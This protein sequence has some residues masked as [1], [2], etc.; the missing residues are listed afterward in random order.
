M[1]PARLADSSGRPARAPVS[2]VCVANDHAVRERTLDRSIADHLH[3]APDTEYL[4]I[5]NSAGTFAS[6][7]EALNHGASVARHD[8]VVFVH[9]DVYLHSLRALEEAANMLAQ[10]PDIGMHGSFGIT[11]NGELVGRIRDRVVVLGQ[12]VAGPTDVDSLDEVLFMV[13]REA[14]LREPLVDAPDLAWHAYAVEYG[15]RVRSHGKRVTA[16]RIPLTHNSLTVNVDRLDVA[17]RAVARRHPSALPV[18]TTCGVISSPRPRSKLLPAHRWRYRWLR[19]SLVAHRARHAVGSGP[20]VLSDIRHDVDEAIV[21]TPGV[22]EIINLEHEPAA[23]GDLQSEAVELM[24]RGQR[25]L[26]RS[27]ALAELTEAVATW[28]PDRSL[29]I[30]NLTLSDLRRLRDRLSA[31]QRLVA[32]HHSIGCWL[33]LGEAAMRAEAEAFSSRRSRPFGMAR[34]RPAPAGTRRVSANASPQDGAA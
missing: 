3:E 2:I 4:P 16:G 20:V 19:G 10:R 26:V 30:T 8:T 5:D 22:L 13:R 21:G 12:P 15:L 32:Y 9:Q 27:M 33:M 6:A 25:V 7:G 24:R 17:H 28:P 23:L 29:L 1:Q 14:L 18:R 11:A 31:H 34:L